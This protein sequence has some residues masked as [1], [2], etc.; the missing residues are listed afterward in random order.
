MYAAEKLILKYPKFYK[1]THT[2]FCY[3]QLNKQFICLRILFVIHRIQ[4]SFH[5]YPLFLFCTDLQKANILL[6]KSSLYLSEM[7][8][9]GRRSINVS[10][11]AMLSNKL[12]TFNIDKMKN[13]SFV[14]VQ[15]LCVYVLFT[16]D[17]IIPLQNPTYRLQ[18][19]VAL[20]DRILK[21]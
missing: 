4:P 15:S 21:L 19:D 5:L 10:E 6:K 16:T 20:F 14:C 11:C 9:I 1:S 13:I 18:N 2:F 7:V 3:F 8:V 17:N 12:W